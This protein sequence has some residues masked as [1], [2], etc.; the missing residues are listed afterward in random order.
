MTSF[1]RGVLGR[2]PF[3]R[4]S[5]AW[6]KRCESRRQF[7]RDYQRFAALSASAQ[8]HW[9]LRWEDRYPC[10]NDRTASTDF[11]HHYVYH[12]A[13]AA[14]LLA[15]QRPAYHVDISS[16]VYFCALVSAFLPVRFFDYRPADLRLSNL[17]SEHADLTRL[18]FGD[19][20]VDS[21]SCMHVVEHI[22]LGRYG[23]P[24]DPDGDR[25]A[26]CELQRVLAP[27]G[28]LL[29]VVPV[30]KP[31]IMFNAHRIYAYSQI[32]TAFTGLQ[33]ARFDLITDRPSDGL[34]ENAPAEAADGQSYGCGC[35]WFRRP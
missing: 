20:S 10:L 1:A 28:S 26:M 6:F 9:M 19:L 18:P 7:R 2:V 35:F 33:L 11:D 30:G 4:S 21:L 16:N 22:G 27:K 15:D 8:A 31:K 17:S 23:D 5:Y 34:I 14:R 29:F 24:L 3:A 13:W 25:K 12:T 32:M